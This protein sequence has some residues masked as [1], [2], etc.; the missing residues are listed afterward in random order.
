MSMLDKKYIYFLEVAKAG[1]F[2]AA[3]RKL[4]MSQSAVS[5]QIIL[6]ED[7]MQLKLFE[8]SGYKPKLTAEGKKLYAFLS[9][10]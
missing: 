10:F 6:L 2:S 5:Q 3:A 4:Y 7:E 9:D 8:R 1:S